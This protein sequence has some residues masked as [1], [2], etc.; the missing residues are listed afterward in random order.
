MN[1]GQEGLQLRGDL[2]EFPQQRLGVLGGRL[3]F[4]HEQVLH[5]P[6]FELRGAF[7]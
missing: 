4:L 1:A 6:F 5:E 7:L 2:H 3:A